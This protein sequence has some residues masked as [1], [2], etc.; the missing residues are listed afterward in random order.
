MDVPLG[1][2][3][4]LGKI[5]LDWYILMMHQCILKEKKVTEPTAQY[6]FRNYHSYTDTIIFR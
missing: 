1:T 4:T 6:V 2:P 3:P 5:L